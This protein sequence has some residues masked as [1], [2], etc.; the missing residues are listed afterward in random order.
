MIRH[1]TAAGL[2]ARLAASYS[3][4]SAVELAISADLK[5]C[6]GEEAL[7][8]GVQGLEEAT[9]ASGFLVRQSPDHCQEH[10]L[11]EEAHACKLQ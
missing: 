11:L 5:L 6:S 8:R 10:S 3:I 2:H 9:Q 1:K 7:A 4:E